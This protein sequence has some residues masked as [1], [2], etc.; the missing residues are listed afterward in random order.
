MEEKD[1]DRKQVLQ[2]R[3]ARRSGHKSTG[4]IFAQDGGGTAGPRD[5]AFSQPTADPTLF[6]EHT[7]AMKESEKRYRDLVDGAPVGVYQ[8]TR[9]GDIIYVNNTLAGM[10]GFDTPEK[11]ASNGAL[12]LYKNPADRA[13]IIR[14]LDHRGKVANREVEFVTR[15]GRPVNVLLS[16]TLD[17]GIISGMM[18]DITERRKAIKDLQRERETF[19]SI[20]ENDPS[21]VVLIDAHGVYQYVNP[22][23]THITGYTIKDVPTGKVWFEKAYPDADYRRKAVHMWRTNRLPEGRSVDVEFTITCKDGQTKDVE[24]RTSHLKRGTVTVLVDITRRRDTERALHESEEKY[25]SIFENAMEG[26]FQTTPEGRFLSVNPALA[27]IYGYDSPQELIECITNI[28]EQ[29]YVDPKDRSLLVELYRKRGFVEGFETQL[30]R[31]DQSKVW[32]SMSARAIYGPEGNVLRYE[33]TI[34]NITARKE[35]EAVE[36]QLRQSQKMEALGTLAGG[37]A[38]DFNNILTGI[39]GFSEMLLDDVPPGN[40]MHRKLEL[41]FRSARRGYDLVRQILAFSRKGGTDK[42]PVQLGALIRDVVKMLRAT[43]PSTIDIREHI[44]TGEDLILADQVQIHQILLNL[45]TNG[46]HAMGN[47]GGVLEISLTAEQPALDDHPS[48]GTDKG[49]YVKI[50]VRDTGS[51]MAPDVVERVFDPFFTTK[52]PGEGTGL[53]LSVVHGI[54]KGHGGLISVWSKPHEGS[55]FSVFLPRLRPKCA[56]A[57]EVPQVAPTGKGRV[58]LVDD[59]EIIAEM[60]KERLERLGYEVA[61]TTSSTEA[62]VMFRSD[63]SSFDLVITDYTMP[64]MTGIGLAAEMIALRPDTPIIL[65]SG[66]NDPVSSKRLKKVGIRGFLTKPILKEDLAKLIQFVL[67]KPVPS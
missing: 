9:D 2:S 66:L 52:S 7:N 21:G 37:I 22:E 55:L 50:A 11:A 3:P 40:P 51:G 64:V 15:T 49:P 58:L 54:I 30:Y 42:K 10:L 12:D 8:T 28:R 47:K 27:R 24:F 59:E 45:C 60:G 13:A 14:I 65:C 26:I 46:V 44:L 25:R 20:L 38:H 48:G 34:E 57:S 67:K 5:P 19:Y 18:I 35:K 43:T 36:A 4:R 39:I 17:G 32:I 31:K 41:I 29:M 23:F 62:L 56:P 16:A 61:V 1:T 63:P 33:G 6:A 53:G